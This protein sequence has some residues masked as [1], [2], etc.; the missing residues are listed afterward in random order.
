[1]KQV[2][3][4]S[5]TSIFG[6]LGFIA[7]APA[8]ALAQG[9]DE[10]AD[11]GEIIVTAQR[12]DE[13][14]VDVPITITS[15]S[16]Q[17]LQTA[18]VQDLPDIV[19]VT[20]GLRFDNAG[21][22]FQPT[23]RGVGT[24]VVTSGGGSN[25]GI[26]VDNFYIP[27]I[28]AADFKLMKV[29]SISVLKG[30]QGTLFGHNTTGGAIQLTTA[31][32]SNE[33]AFEG[34]VSYGRFNEFTM[35]AYATAGLGDR[36]AFDIEGM[37]SRGDGWRT[38]ISNNQRVGD[39]RSWSVRAGLK[40]EL[41]DAV[42]VLLRYQHSDVNDPD[43]LLTSTYVDP[44]FGSGAPIFALPSEV[45]F[46]KN[47]IAS[48]SNPEDQ[49]FLRIK[50]DV[51]QGTIKADLGFANLASYTQFRKENTDSNIEID[52]SGSHVFELRLPNGNK[53]FTQELLLT[54]KQGSRLQWTA[55]FY[56]FQNEDIYTTFFSD[57]GVA[58]LT[59]SDP[60]PVV[61]TPGFP[62]FGVAFNPP[63]R[64]GGSGTKVK[65]V[66]G[67]FDMTYELTPQLFL[68]AGARYS[69]NSVTDAYFNG[70][71][72]PSG[73]A[74][75]DPTY[76]RPLASISGNKL[77]PRAVLRYKPN[78]QSSIYA[79]F[80][81]GFK[82]AIIDA[83][84]TCQNPINL[85]TPENPTGAGFVCSN[86]KPEKINAFEIG[87]K[88]NDRRLS[89][90]LSGFYY[91]YKNL[92]VSVYLAGR[93]NI[94]NAATS[95]IY[96]LDGQLSYRVNDNFQFN[97]GAAWTHA[98]YTDFPGAPVYSKCTT[99]PG[100]FGGIGGTTFEVVPTN[101]KDGTMQRAPAFTGNIGARYATDLAG[102]QLALSGNLYYS[103]KVFFGPSGNQFPQKGFATLSLR[104][105]WTDSSERFTVA[106][107]G[108]NVTNSRYLTQV[109]ASSFGLGA[110]WNKPATYGVELGVKF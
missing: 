91:D 29:K 77:T 45:T 104:G 16:A 32:P 51:W 100:C 12:R 106:V 110:N 2:S 79:S 81:Q 92:Q 40:F 90:E 74:P 64:I 30:P 4:R 35:Q 9:S 109:Q 63:F 21:A 103:S 34:K 58:V 46:D 10:G 73:A 83:G 67:Y 97:L 96:G 78:D 7:L 86:I 8:P 65:A 25:V 5:M 3:L 47:E 76:K 1:M 26:Y 42:S 28:L 49:E 82:S 17:Q 50:S 14:Q 53:T 75:G 55:G 61:A 101:I 70:F 98:R 39:W 38:N 89:V 107:F 43:P 95:K 59:A 84:G 72:D 44:V 23:I 68:T 66:A 60:V 71:F 36:I 24:P 99:F 18:N 37:Y 57:V 33:P 13:K 94:V 31:E 20:P 27:N 87:Y 52:Y 15:I 62:M 48:G 41:S 56:Y 6:L 88:Y 22:Y 19:K 102:G 93:A 80:T 108:D 105:Q 11:S 54:S 69:H 85:P